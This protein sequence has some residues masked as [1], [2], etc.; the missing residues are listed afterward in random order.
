VH[1]HPD[2]AAAARSA[3]QHIAGSIHARLREAPCFCLALSGGSTPRMM[4]EALAQQAL[5]WSR[6]EIFQVD[7]RVAPAGD[8][9]RNLSM[10]HEALVQPG[11]LPEGNLHA[12]PVENADLG[13]AARAY[14]RALSAAAGSP[15]VL[16]LV[17]LG[18]GDDGHTASL[19]PADP[20]MNEGELAVAITDEYRGHRRMTL[21]YP[22]LNTAR[23]RLWLATGAAKAGMLAR[24]YAADLD[25]PAGRVTQRQAV[26]FTDV[27]PGG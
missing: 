4:L 9:A 11:L 15:P 2:P 5:P 19:V 12:M 18:L 20:A 7:E 17:H 23:Q 27:A 16:D 26:V 22:V 21:T 6:L 3:A 25:I 24:L 10:V 13:A 8:P 1:H 14:A